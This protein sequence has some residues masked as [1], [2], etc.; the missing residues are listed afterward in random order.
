M[1]KFSW[2]R[3]PAAAFLVVA[4]MEA[5]NPAGA[6]NLN[7]LLRIFGG[8]K[9]RAVRQAQA[10][11]RRLRPAEAACIDQRLRRKGSS[12]EAL[13][14]RGV[15]PSATRLIELRSSCREF[16]GGV[17][18]DTA[19]ALVGGATGSPTPTVPPSNPIE[20][21]DAGVTS[22]AESLKDSSVA[23]PSPETTVRRVAEEQVQGDV[24]PKNSVPE[25]GIMGWLSAV[26]LFVLA[27]IVTLV[28][29]FIYAFIRW[30]TTRQRMVAMSLAENNSEGAGN[31][32]LET[33]IGAAGDAMK[34]LAKKMIRR[35]NQTGKAAGTL[36]TPDSAESIQPTHE[37]VSPAI[38][39]FEGS[40]S[41]FIDNTA[42]ENVAQLA[43]LCA[44]GTPSEKDFQRIKGLISQSMG[45]AQ[46]RKV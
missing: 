25:R 30:R 41:S 3:L 8:D 40:E 28:C 42:V 35:P 37:E 45:N 1:G 36:M 20:P 33:T 6:Q 17:Q 29:V 24:E 16:V 12:V 44:K 14:R 31:T 19:P 11:W 39:P 32:L 5:A 13:I 21:K 10:E 26:F 27:A 43:E 22:S 9:Q 23:P 7:D 34:T 38:A 46:E 18:T 2:M 4:V 15:K